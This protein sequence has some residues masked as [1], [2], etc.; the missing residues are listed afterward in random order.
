MKMTKDD[1][2]VCELAYENGYYAGY[3]NA[4]IDNRERQV[5]SL[6]SVEELANLKA[7][8]FRSRIKS[9]SHSL[10]KMVNGDSMKCGSRLID[11]IKQGL[12]KKHAG[13]D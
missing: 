11:K 13:Q 8:K 9:K 3:I 2:R 4:Q 6:K 12:L 10:D 1:L 5:L 7:G